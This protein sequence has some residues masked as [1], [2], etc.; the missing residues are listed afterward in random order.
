MFTRKVVRAATLATLFAVALVPPVVRA[1]TGGTGSSSG[2]TGSS[3]QSTTKGKMPPTPAAMRKMQPQQIFNMMDTDH[4]GYVTKDD[5]M[6]FQEQLFNTWDKD[7]S[8]R[9]AAPVFTDEG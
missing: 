9:I 6:K 3:D 1:Q 5:F 7:K 2:D 4:K 8:G